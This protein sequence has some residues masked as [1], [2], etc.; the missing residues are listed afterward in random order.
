MKVL[1]YPDLSWSE[2]LMCKKCGAKLL[3]EIQ[4]VILESTG[5]F[6]V[7]CLVCG[8]RAHAKEVLPWF[9]QAYARGLPVGWPPGQKPK[10]RN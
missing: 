9:V 6:F 5:R 8:E 1:E 10:S 7:V 3:A 2:E 4:D